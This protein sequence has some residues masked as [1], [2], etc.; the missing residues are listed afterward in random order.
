MT[1]FELR[2][3]DLSHTIY[4]DCRGDWQRISANAKLIGQRSQPMPTSPTPQRIKQFAFG[5][6]PTLIIETAI[7]HRVFDILDGGARTVE[8]MAAATGASVR[9]LRPIM[10]ALVGLEF[11]SKDNQNRYALTPESAAFLVSTKPAFQGGIFRHASRQLVPKWL[12]LNEIVRTGR[13]ALS[14]NQNKQG[15]E[16]FHQFVEDIFSMSR[17][18]AKILA[19]ALNLAKADK[20]VRVLDLAA[21]SGVW[22][23]SLAEASPQV[24]VSALDWEGVLP[25]TRRVT[26]KFGV[27]DRFDFIAG[28]L[29]EV[30]F[31]SNYN[32]ATLGHI[33]HSEGEARSRQLLKKTFKALAPGG[34]IAIAEFVV[35]ADRTGPTPSLIFAVNM[36]VNT[37]NGGTYSFEE[38]SDWLKE[39]GF[40][41]V[42]ALDVHSHSPLILADK[43]R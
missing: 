19:E 18:P 1:P 27:Q 10:D 33:L 30:D 21:G 42:R 6:A 20:P 22:G 15:V 32:I 39:A 40:T 35:N 29:G 5:Y 12:D 24:H 13:P 36:L 43:S 7:H 25:V 17:E 26:E 16:F 38:M 37:Q 4:H 28:D 41:N 8:Q 2:P 14:A 23:I 9:G 3:K 31:G 34:T 11:L